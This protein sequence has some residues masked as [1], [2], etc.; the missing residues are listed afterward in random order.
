MIID[1]PVHARN[2]RRLLTNE[3]SCHVPDLAR[4]AGD[5]APLSARQWKSSCDGELQMLFPRSQGQLQYS[6]V[7]T[8]QKRFYFQSRPY[9][10]L[11]L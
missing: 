5:L 4:V 3:V 10:S 8:T 9:L 7:A 2:I 11:P 6:E 1:A